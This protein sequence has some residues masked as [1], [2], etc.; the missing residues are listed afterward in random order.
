MRR[1]LVVALVATVALSGCSAQQQSATDL[2]FDIYRGCLRDF[3][4]S[5]VR[6][7]ALQ[8]ISSVAEQ[9]EIKITNLMSVVRTNHD[10]PPPAIQGPRDARFQLFESFDNFL[11]THS[12]KITP[13]AFFRSQDARS[14]IPDALLE[15]GLASEMNVPLGGTSTG[16]TEGW[17]HIFLVNLYFI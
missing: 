9:D 8:W 16:V 10:L 7:K 14:M 13:P 15:T 11:N 6:P 2:A 12:V 4:T 1:F 17:S 5:C 3:S